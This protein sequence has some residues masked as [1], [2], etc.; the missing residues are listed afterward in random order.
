MSTFDGRVKEFPDIRI[1]YFRN[2]P[3][4]PPPLAYFLSHV[5]SDH[6]TGLESC[7]SPF[8]YCSP[9]TRDLLLRLEKYPHRMNFA[10]GILES[11]RQTYG[12]LRK[13]LKAIP[14]K[15]A[16]WIELCPGRRV[17]GILA[18]PDAG[19]DPVIGVRADS[20]CV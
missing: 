15:T 16:T 10:K 6:L 7:K 1:D 5:H 3:A 18:C 19:S 17:G 12:H 8:I 9:A 11:R 2:H 13:L 14:L 20:R 4:D